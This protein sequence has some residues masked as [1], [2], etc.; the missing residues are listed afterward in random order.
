MTALRLI[1]DEACPGAVNMARDEALLDAVA[2]RT[3]PPTLRC[4]G[5]REPTIS[6]GYFQAFA[7]HEAL[8]PPAGGLPVVRRMTGGGAILHDLEL[9]YAIALPIDHAWLATGG[10]ALYVLVHESMIRAIGGTARL[11]GRGS[12]GDGGC[13]S[14]M[15][16][17]RDGNAPAVIATA[18]SGMNRGGMIEGGLDNARSGMG[19]ACGSARR[20]PFF[21]CARRT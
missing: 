15:E 11:A 8:P 12:D 14:E 19:G 6:L 9:T 7:D 18:G 3:A 5:W 13:D 1:L 4:Y 20:G 16:H 17:A 21:C 10:N 2:A